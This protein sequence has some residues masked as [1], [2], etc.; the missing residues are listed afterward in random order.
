MW[1]DVTV[2]AVLGMTWVFLFLALFALVIK[3]IS[4]C[5]NKPANPEKNRD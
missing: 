1:N 3:L 4:R 5:V 2:I